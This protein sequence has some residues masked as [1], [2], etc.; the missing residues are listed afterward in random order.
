MATAPIHLG[1]DVR[2]PR[3]EMV[4]LRAVLGIILAVERHRRRTARLLDGIDDLG[5]AAVVAGVTALAEG[6]IDAAS[7]VAH[8]ADDL[9][10]GDVRL[11]QLVAHLGE[12]TSASPSATP[13]AAPGRGA[14][15]PRPRRPSASAS[16][17][18]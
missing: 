1:R 18:S 2:P 12:L 9:C 3:T 15:G 14:G 6:R 16:P 7:L 10:A 8:F 5:R 4:D 17:Q 13:R 11:E